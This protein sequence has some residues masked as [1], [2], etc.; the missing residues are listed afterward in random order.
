MMKSPLQLGEQRLQGTAQITCAAR[1]K[2]RRGARCRRGVRLVLAVGTACGSGVLVSFGSPSFSHSARPCMTRNSA[3]LPAYGGPLWMSTGRASRGARRCLR[4]QAG[5]RQQ[6][7]PVFTRSSARPLAAAV[8]FGLLPATA[9]AEAD[10]WRTPK[11]TL[12]QQRWNYWP[13]LPVAPYGRRVTI[14]KEL[15]PGEL[16]AFDQKL[17]I[18]YVQVP[19]RMTVYRMRSRRG[20]FVYAPVAPTE[21]CVALLR[22]LEELHG[23]VLYVVLPTCAV[24]HK[25]FCRTSKHTQALALTQT[26]ARSFSSG[27]GPLHRVP[28]SPRRAVAQGVRGGGQAPER[29]RLRILRQLLL[30]WFGRFCR[31]VGP[32]SRYFPTAQVWVAPGQFSVPLPLAL[33]F[34]GFPGDRL[35]TLPKN[36]QDASV[37]RTGAPRA[38]TTAC[39]GRSASSS[40]LEPSQRRCSTCGR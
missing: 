6:N 3:N 27:G 32:F 40:T 7:E 13:V 19:I 30:V 22:E 35:R 33:Q 26:P 8:A 10:T 25:W 11:P 31:F 4:G 16:W 5:Q 38:S 36:P 28:L 37:R 23:P 12:P 2:P 9:L 24:E 34:L 15:V 20:L 14:R 18:Y 29:N 39:W 1:L 21:E 17:G